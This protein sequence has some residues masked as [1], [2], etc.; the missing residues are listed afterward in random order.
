MPPEASQ[1]SKPEVAPQGRNRVGILEI[2]DVI[3]K[4]VAA[5]A[6]VLGAIIANSYQSRMTGTTILSQREQSET[7]L[8][9]SM[10]S[11]LI[12]PVVGLQ[13]GGVISPD[14]ERLLVELLALNFHEHFEL[15]PLILHA[16][17]RL[18]ADRPEGMSREQA[19]SARASLRSIA[20]RVTSQQIASLIREGGP[21]Q[22]QNQ[23]CNSYLL[24]LQ[25][26]TSENEPRGACQ[27]RGSFEDVMRV[28]SPDK[29]YTLNVVASN[30]NWENETFNVGVNLM[31]NT[32]AEGQQ[33]QDIAYNFALTWFDLP[34]TDN[35]LLPDG[36]R[37]ALTLAAVRKAKDATFRLIWFPKDYITPRERPLDYR[38]YLQLVG[39]Q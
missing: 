26:E 36:N 6:L 15:K 22:A 13:K 5:S 29:R 31:T 24:T 9:A 20:R 17:A 38:Q 34:L 10:F 32:P 3:A 8:R 37:F 1:E 12:E 11:S 2:I 19:Q 27:L 18:A 16:D 25:T 33:Y 30:P 39:K 28:E 4:L 35:T 23:G 7:Q 21:A 14:R